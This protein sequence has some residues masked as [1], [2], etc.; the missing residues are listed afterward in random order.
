M[1]PDP[2][3]PSGSYLV[4]ITASLFRLV[5]RWTR[6]DLAGWLVSVY[7]CDTLRAGVIA[8]FLIHAMLCR[9]HGRMQCTA[10]VHPSAIVTPLIPDQRGRSCQTGFDTWF[11]LAISATVPTTLIYMTWVRLMECLQLRMQDIDFSRNKVVVPDGEGVADRIAML[12]VSL[13]ASLQ[14]HLEQVKAVH[15]QGLTA[16]S[17]RVQMPDALDR[18]YPNPPADWRRQCVFP[19]ATLEQQ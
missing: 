15:G 11:A 17:R 9:L 3:P 13:K 5:S 10:S 2:T 19:Q 4:G 14:K 6:L 16:G 8:D 7:V 12:P 18:E 1:I